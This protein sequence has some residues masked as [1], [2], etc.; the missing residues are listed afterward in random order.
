VLYKKALC[1]N[2]LKCSSGLALPRFGEQLYVM[3][4]SEPFGNS[5][6][7][8]NHL[9]RVFGLSAQNI[10]FP[11]AKTKKK[12]QTLTGTGKRKKKLM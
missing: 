7:S 4:C 1:R 3:K 9:R 5:I 2:T 10:T 12:H 6:F 8:F 11:F